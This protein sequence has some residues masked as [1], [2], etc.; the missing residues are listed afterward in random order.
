MLL[1]DNT[2]MNTLGTKYQT[3]TLQRRA[4]FIYSWTVTKA[5]GKKRFLAVLTVGL[6]IAF[7]ATD[8]LK[9][10]WN[11]NFDING[12]LL[13]L[14]VY[15]IVNMIAAAIVWRESERAYR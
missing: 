1:P 11:G 4:R 13:S 8:S 2:T 3:W 15:L 6:T 12:L 14:P 5:K 9:E 10:L 7:L